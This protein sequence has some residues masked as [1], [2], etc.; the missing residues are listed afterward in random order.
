MVPYLIITAVCCVWISAC[1]QE[2]MPTPIS[3]SAHRALR[4]ADHRCRTGQPNAQEPRGRCDLSLPQA[5]A[6]G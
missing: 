6:V 5:H 3:S 1:V 2:A 4:S